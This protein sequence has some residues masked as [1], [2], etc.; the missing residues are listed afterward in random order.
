MVIWE[1]TRRQKK[2]EKPN[3]HMT[4]FSL[5]ISNKRCLF[6]GKKWLLMEK[7][8]SSIRKFYF[9]SINFFIINLFILYVCIIFLCN[10]LHKT[11]FAIFAVLTCVTSWAMYLT[12]KY[13]WK[14]S[15]NKLRGKSMTHTTSKQELFVTLVTTVN[16]CHK[17][18]Y[19]R[20][21]RGPRYPSETSYYKKFENEEM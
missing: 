16:Y 14:T 13:L 7:K 20:R 12:A 5:F 3:N 17:D 4:V 2:L 8:F 15:P 1:S 19:Y 11:G 9:H 21:C 18:I 10:Y 6:L